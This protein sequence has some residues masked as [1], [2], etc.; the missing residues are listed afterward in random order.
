MMTRKGKRRAEM[1]DAPALST[2]G[3]MRKMTQMKVVS[4]NMQGAGGSGG[5]KQTYLRTLMRQDGVIAICLQECG[6]LFGWTNDD[7]EPG[8]TIAVHRQ[9]NA[10]GA[11]NR[12]S[13]AVL[14]SAVVLARHQVEA[15]LPTRRPIV[16]A[17]IT[18]RWI[19][20]VHA[21]AGGNPGYVAAALGAVR[22]WAGD[23]PWIAVGDMNL[24]PG[25][26]AAPA[27]SSEISSGQATHQSGGELDYGYAGGR[28]HSHWAVRRFANRGSDHWPVEFEIPSAR[29]LR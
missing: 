13:L 7:L 1:A 27:E 5:G 12:C 23:R 25:T 19:F 24:A 15:T 9:W 6:G 18:N 21:P 3:K 17:C 22:T 11:G 16:G 4:W 8:W 20:S 29:W 2:R 26:V 28:W 10:G 14:S